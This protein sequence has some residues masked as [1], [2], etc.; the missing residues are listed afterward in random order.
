MGPV[1]AVQHDRRENDAAEAAS[2]DDGAGFSA[3]NRGSGVIAYT[4]LNT[5]IPGSAAET[6]VHEIGHNWDNENPKWNE[7]LGLSGWQKKS[8]AGPGQALSTDGKWVYA[9]DK[10][11]TFASDYGKTNP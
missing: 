9:A 10:A 6:T 3:F 1:P 5:L 2:N 8:T 4:R 7:W 11:D